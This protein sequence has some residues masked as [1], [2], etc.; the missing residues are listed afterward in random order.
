M[1]FGLS[2]ILFYDFYSAT[3][4]R[5]A[6]LKVFVLTCLIFPILLGGLIEIFQPMYFARDAS[7]FDWLADIFGAILGFGLM[8]KIKKLPISFKKNN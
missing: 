1:Y 5:N 7:W 4:N 6:V 8:M 3:K 2:L